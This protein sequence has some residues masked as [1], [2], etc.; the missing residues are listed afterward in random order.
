MKTVAITSGKGGVGKTT[1]SA[2][3]AAALVAEDKSVLVVD[4]DLGLANL[5]IAL[6][7]R[8]EY[9]LEHVL[10]GTVSLAEAITEGPGGVQFLAGGSGVDRLANL[11]EPD[12]ESLLAQLRDVAQDLDFLLFDTGAGISEQVMRFVVTAD[13]TIVVITPDP[14]SVTDGYAIAKALHARRPEATMSLLLNMAD[15]DQQ[16]QNVADKLRHVVWQFLGA[17]LKVMGCVTRDPAVAQCVRQRKLFLLEAPACTASHSIRRA[18]RTLATLREPE[19]ATPFFARFLAS[20][21]KAA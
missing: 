14:A 1:L 5:D 17:E 3:L 12:L 6:G 15:T 16:A 21:W 18:A 13:E 19:A 4:A 10:A 2:N 11:S 7:V 8:P 20:F 9:T